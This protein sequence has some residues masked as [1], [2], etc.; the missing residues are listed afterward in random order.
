MMMIITIFPRFSCQADIVVEHLLQT[1][2]PD[3]DQ[4]SLLPLT[5]KPRRYILFVIIEG[6][7]IVLA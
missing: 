6:N 4:L 5:I 1:V 2:A 7:S 3:P